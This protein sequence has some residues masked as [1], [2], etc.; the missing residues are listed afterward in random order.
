MNTIYIDIPMTIIV[1]FAII[2]VYSTSMP[3][4]S[5]FFCLFGLAGL[6]GVWLVLKLIHL[7][8]VHIKLADIETKN[9]L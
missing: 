8:C 6:V 7:R 1:I 2:V 3:V 4:L 5:F 9:D